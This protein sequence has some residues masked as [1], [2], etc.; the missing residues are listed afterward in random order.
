ML[1]LSSRHIEQ[2]YSGF[3]IKLST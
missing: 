1:V 3:A 2:I